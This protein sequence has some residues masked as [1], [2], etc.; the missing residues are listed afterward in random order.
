MTSRRFI[1]GHDWYREGADF[2]VRQQAASIG[3]G[4]WIGPGHAENDP[5][6]ATSLAMLFLSKGR[7]PVVMAKLRHGPGED[8]NRTAT[9]W[10]TWWSTSSRGGSGN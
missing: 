1:G 7:R 3:E 10:P 4:Y 8:W 9:T 2:L 5:V 6:I